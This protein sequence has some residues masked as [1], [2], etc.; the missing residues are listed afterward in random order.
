MTRTTLDLSSYGW[1]FLRT[2]DKT[3]EELK[4][5][6]EIAQRLRNLHKRS[7]TPKAFDSGIAVSIFRDKSTR[8]KYSY[9]AAAN[10]LGL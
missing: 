6:V 5:T 10:F 4:A 9:A 2:W 7:V 3:V 1:D 8:T